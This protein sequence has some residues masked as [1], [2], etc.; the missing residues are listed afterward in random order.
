MKIRELYKAILE[1]VGAIVNDDG[2]ISLTRP[3]AEAIPFMV[4]D[5][6]LAMPTDK[7]LNEGAFNP[8]GSLIAFHPMCENVVLKT[9]PVLAKLETAMIFRLTWVLRELVMQLVTVAADPKQH[10]KLKMRA[11]GL[12]SA[13]PNAD[14]RTRNDYIKVMQTTT[15]TG[16]K[17]MLSLYVR[18]G[19]IYDGEKVNRLGRFYP[20]IVDQLDQEKRTLHGVSLR[21]ADVPAFLA[22]IEYILP[23]YHDNDRYASP[24]NAL[25]A[26]T[27]HALVKT[28]YKIAN[29]LNKVIEIH[30]GQLADPEQL[31]I[32]IDWIESVQ[33]LTQY[34]EM[35]PVLPGNDGDEGT[36]QVKTPAAKP[37]TAGS[38]SEASTTTAAVKPTKA[39]H[40]KGISVDELIKGMTPPRQAFQQQQ[41]ITAVKPVGMRAQQANFFQQQQ[42]DDDLPPWARKPTPGWSGQQ[43][44]NQSA[45]WGN[46]NGGNWNRNGGGAL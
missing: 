14:E 36:K 42:Q 26:P 44:A 34:R 13:L 31:K 6:R 7:F 18:P 32:R 8:T 38:G 46:N 35:I 10:K 43:E 45:A 11:H 19:G 25:V 2:L 23:E 12:L 3:D 41:P 17:K 30:E 33:E 39:S 22:L 15:A 40:A 27:F 4:N 9:S 5:K 20:T 16:Q 37:A 24:S 1:G 21:K 28:Y 29:Q